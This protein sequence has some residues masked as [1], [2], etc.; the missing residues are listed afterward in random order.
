MKK[1]I[2]ILVS[3]CFLV[4]M[5]GVVAYAVDTP[6]KDMTP[7]ERYFLPEFQ[8]EIIFVGTKIDL[9]LNAYRKNQKGDFYGVQI[10]SIEKT[11][12]ATDIGIQLF[13][14][15]VVWDKTAHNDAYEVEEILESNADIF[16]VATFS[17]YGSGDVNKDGE[18]D[19]YDYILCSRLYFGTYEATDLEMGYADM[20][21]DGEIT[22]YDYILIKRCYF[23]TYSPVL[24]G[25]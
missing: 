1:T 16:S 25:E 12:D 19:Q 24:D 2:A 10:I 15:R 3:L 14:Y 20:E 8:S 13:A 21:K 11:H 9:D 17:L 22:V 5:F 18:V 4:S 6:Y 7:N 23:G